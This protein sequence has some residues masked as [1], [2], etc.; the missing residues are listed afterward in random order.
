[1]SLWKAEN[2][3]PLA[4]SL[5]LG[6]SLGCEMN[7]FKAFPSTCLL[8]LKDLGQ[9]S[10]GLSANPQNVPLLEASGCSGSSG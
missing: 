2:R 1:M 4:C 6:P 3:D 9:I 10:W 5:A 7:E 8:L